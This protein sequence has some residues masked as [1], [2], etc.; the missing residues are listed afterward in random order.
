[1]SVQNGQKVDAAVTNAAF[2]SRTTD[3]NTT[4]KV[5]LENADSASGAN[6]S[7][8]Q[9]SINGAHSFAGSNPNGL[10]DQTPTWVN[11][12]YGSSANNLQA[13]AE[14]HDVAIKTN[15]D[16]IATNTQELADV[17]T[18]LGSSFGN[19]DMG[20]YSGST[21]SDNVD[22]STINQELETAVEARILLT[23]KG[24]AN[25]VAPLNGSSLIDSIYLPSY[26]DDV[27]EFADLASFPVT[28][29]TGKLY[30]AIDTGK[31]Y[32]WSGSIYVEVSSN[33]VNSVNGE[34]GVVV[35]DT[36]DIAEGATNKYFNGKDTDDLPEGAVNEYYTDAK[37]DTRIGLASID[38]LAD[39]DTTTV[40]PNVDEALVW[41]GT[42]WVPGEAVGGGGSGLGARSFFSD[43]NCEDISKVSLYD[44]AAAIPVDGDDD[45]NV[46][47][48]S[49]TSETTNPLTGAES[50]KLSKSANN[51]QGE[52]WAI[53]TDVTLDNT[54]KNGEPITVQFKYQTSANYASSDIKVYVYRVGSN[55]LE[56]LNGVD[57]LGSFGNTLNADQTGRGQFTATMNCSSSDTAVRLILHCAS[58]SALAYD[59]MLDNVFIGTS[60]QLVSGINT[61]LEQYIP[62]ITGFGTP[63]DVD[64]RFSRSDEFLTIVGRFTSGTPSGV[65]ASISL[66]GSL[67]TNTGTVGGGVY[68]RATRS[69]GASSYL[70][71]LVLIAPNNSNTIN[72]GAPEL[73][74]STDPLAG[75]AGTDFSGSGQTFFIQLTVP[76]V[77]WSAGNTISSTQANFQN[78]TARYT[79]NSAQS[80]TSGASQAIV[81]FATKSHDDFN[82]VA[83]G[84]SWR[85]TAPAKMTISVKAKFFLQSG[86]S[87]ASGTEQASIYIYK[88][89]AQYSANAGVQTATHTTSIEC[90][91]TDDV[92]LNAEEYI[93]IRVYQNSG[94]T[95]DIIADTALSYVSIT[96]IPD[97]SVV[98]ISGAPFE[99]LIATPSYT[100]TTV[101]DT[102]VDVTGM[103]IQLT[104][105]TWEMGY[106][107]SMYL[108][109]NSGT[110][111]IYGKIVITDSA[112]NEIAN[113]AGLLFS[114]AAVGANSIK[115]ISRKTTVTIAESTTYKVRLKS[116][117]SVAN[118][119]VSI[120]ASGDWTG[121]LAGANDNNSYIY[122]RRLK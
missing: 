62:V 59:V 116:N 99:E 89:G 60:T 34:T 73:S 32:R 13:R 88:N 121:S 100:A 83:T 46:D 28:G 117:L 92:K 3:S 26:V 30:V 109:S 55:T 69:A 61:K 56:A 106:D 108:A 38:D 33:D 2:I 102:Y 14:A 79:K 7:N 96:Q 98:G 85:F 119:E 90:A 42:N 48:V 54:V 111:S 21:I 84:A 27:L 94:S 57:G 50:Y 76:I 64:L 122:A 70:K 80:I 95:L 4:G 112:N 43:Y 29:E 37:V 68:G 15:E 9:R 18:T 65:A 87:W 103:T 47:Y 67:L 97:L 118:G 66:P 1:M 11:N 101:A 113:T 24:A 31:I 16:D 36:D 35:L 5:D 78:V 77:G 10:M 17:R 52:G 23:E 115:S 58:T 114:Y 40:A 110:Q 71:D 20:T 53:L 44:D 8:T 41:D 93:D 45:T 107:A 19:T 91:I 6:I 63:T 72:F 22:Q 75:L 81:D 49:V 74:L 25:G 39:V 82:T 86:A 104:Q 12:N 120:L 105:G 51:A